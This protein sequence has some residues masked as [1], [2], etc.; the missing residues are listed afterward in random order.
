MLVDSGA[1]ASLVY[2][3][4]LRRVGRADEPLRTYHGSLDSVSGHSIQVCG[5]I[6]LPVTLGSVEKT[7]P[8]VVV[9]HL[10]VDAILGADTSRAFRAV[11]DLEEQSLIQ[12]RCGEVVPL[13]D[14]RIEECYVTG[15]ATT[16]KLAPACQALVRANVKGQVDPET[17][18]LIEG[19]AGGD[20]LLRVARTLCTVI[21][22]QVVVEICNTST[23]ELVITKD[24][25]ITVAVVVPETA[26]QGQQGESNKM[27]T[28][29]YVASAASPAAEG[30]DVG[31]KQK[32]LDNRPSDEMKVEF[33]DTDMDE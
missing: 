13:G 25:Q 30:D 24:S 2:E 32:T 31:Q 28:G 20:D 8:F 10:H 4:V 22:G 23:E 5:M 6:D 14:S 1:I 21:H 18:V 9:N 17:T 27:T 16:M 11:I 33:H 19:I 3:R 7:L 29:T 15:I 26:F 12:K